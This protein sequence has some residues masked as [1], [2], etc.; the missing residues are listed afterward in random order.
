MEGCFHV[1]VLL[2]HFGPNII[3]SKATAE[4]TFNSLFFLLF[5]GYFCKPRALFPS[6]LP[7]DGL[8]SCIFL[9][10]EREGFL[11]PPQSGVCEKVAFLNRPTMI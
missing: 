7:V 2:N 5:I 3:V 8:V 9:G 6:Y 1:I 10:Y 4:F 11:L